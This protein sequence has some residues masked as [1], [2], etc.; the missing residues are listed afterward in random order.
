M[1]RTRCLVVLYWNLFASLKET[2]ARKLK[3]TALAI[4]IHSFLL[5]NLSRQI[6]YFVWPK[7]NSNFPFARKIFKWP[8]LSAFCLSPPHF[9]RHQN[10]NFKIYH[11]WNFTF[12]LISPNERRD[13]KHLRRQ[14]IAAPSCIRTRGFS[15]KTTNRKECIHFDIRHTINYIRRHT[16]ANNNVWNSVCAK[17]T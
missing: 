16:M 7:L 15:S 6:H 17:S 13:K 8:I 9:I 5:L 1:G 14:N 11:R 10:N 4:N 2:L 12:N 3:Q